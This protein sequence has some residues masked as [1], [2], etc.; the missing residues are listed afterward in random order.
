M[1]RTFQSPDGQG[2]YLSV[3]LRPNCMPAQ[4][5]HLTCAAGVA[6]MQAVEAVSGI[7][8]QMK[9]INDL[10]VD[11]KKLGGILTEMSVN[12]GLVDYAVVGIGI[13]CLQQPE[14]F[15]PEI[16]GLATSLSLAAG[17]PITP[18]KLAAAMVE[19]L[20]KMDR[21][22]F[23]E[24][25]QLMAEYKENCIT[26]GKEIQVIRQEQIRRGKALD[27]DAEGGLLVQCEDGS[28]E[29]VSSGE[30]SVRGMYGYL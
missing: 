22:L 1:G 16:A 18:A 14:D 11:R 6:M 29:T 26:L 12:K 21:T 30:V 10:V 20:W 2:V 19:A 3:I 13:N 7:R 5:M 28:I 17:H 4:L 23:S 27:L 9:W 24:K 25:A 8:P 15:P